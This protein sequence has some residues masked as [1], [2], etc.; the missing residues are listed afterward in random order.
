MKKK[1]TTTA[2][3]RNAKNYDIKIYDFEEYYLVVKKVN[4][5]DSPFITHI[6]QNIM[7]NGYF[8]LEC[9]PKNEN[10]SMRVFYN[11]KKQPLLYYFDITNEQGLDK[12]TGVPY[13]IDIYNDIMIYTI[14]NKIVVVDEDELKEALRNKEITKA[15]YNK[16]NKVTKQLF[17]ELQD[18]TNQYKNIDFTQFL[19]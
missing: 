14:D 12:E 11:K 15:E 6:G 2:Y 16:A 4:K 17:N 9:T 5:V 13:Y 10:Y 8:V 1:F 19:R 3:M 7:D 18:G